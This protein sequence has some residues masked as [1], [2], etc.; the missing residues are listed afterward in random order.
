M[1]VC[2][3]CQHQQDSGNFCENCG[4]PL[5]SDVHNSQEETAATTSAES[6]NNQMD[7]IKY[8]T[9]NYLDYVVS[10]IKNP[11]M[12]LNQPKS[13]FINGIITLVL[14]AIVL[15]LGF[16]LLINGFYKQTFGGYMGEPSTLPFFSFFFRM[17]FSLLLIILAG[18]VALVA[19]LKIGKA[20]VSF[21]EALAQYGAF[22]VPFTAVSALTILTGLA[23]APQ[24]TLI[25]FFIGFIAFISLA[26]VII[27]FHH[28][29]QLGE[30]VQYVYLSIG[31]FLLTNLIIY[32]LF[33][34]YLESTLNQIDQIMY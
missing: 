29:S 30:K 5:T 26:P 14:M 10:L 31:S 28:L 24:L 17:A 3:N 12:S 6:Q 13:S 33:R 15:S 23:T 25:L 16:Y 7:N 20:D 8:H 2:E 27:S 1:L 9:K 22:S 11:T 32:I 4:T 19:V 21:Q 18:L 34:I